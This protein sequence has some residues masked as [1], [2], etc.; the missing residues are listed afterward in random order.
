MVVGVRSLDRRRPFRARRISLVVVIVRVL[1][2]VVSSVESL[3]ESADDGL[4]G[5]VVGV[6]GGVKGLEVF[7][8]DGSADWFEAGVGWL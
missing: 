5:R 4:E 6:A 8:I 3:L 7:Q 2:V 1:D